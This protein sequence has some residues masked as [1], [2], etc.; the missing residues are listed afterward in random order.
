[1]R[2]SSY[3]S[4]SNSRRQRLE[5]SG[6]VWSVVYEDPEPKDL[7]P[8]Y[9]GRADK[10]PPDTTYNREQA[11]GLKRVQARVFRSSHGRHQVNYETN[12]ENTGTVEKSQRTNY[13]KCTNTNALD[14]YLSS[15]D[16]FIAACYVYFLVKWSEWILFLVRQDIFGSKS[17]EY[18]YLSLEDPDQD[19]T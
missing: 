11:L 16:Q 4:C 12:V 8:I 15:F 9:L 14:T 2:T 1:M 10:V 3:R 19:I 5:K 6:L 7:L 17:L 18:L 13:N